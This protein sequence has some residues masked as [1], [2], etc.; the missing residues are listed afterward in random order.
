MK[1]V[2]L[3]KLGI[4]VQ[5]HSKMKLLG[6]FL[7]IAGFCHSQTPTLQQVT[8]AGNATT[9][10]IYVN[11]ILGVDANRSSII[12]GTGNS[13][14]SGGLNGQ[15]YIIG[16][17][18]TVYT[19]SFQAV[20][21]SANN[22]HGDANAVVGRHNTAGTISNSGL[23]L[24]YQNTMNS[25]KGMS[26]GVQNE[27]YAAKASAFGYI[28]K[29]YGYES[30]AL[31]I[32]NY[33]GS[34]GNRAVAFGVEN[35]SLGEK[36]AAFGIE[37]NASGKKSAAFGYKCTTSGLYSYAFGKENTVTSTRGVAIGCN[38]SVIADYAL[39]FGR[40]LENNV[41]SSVK[42]GVSNSA[43]LMI[44]NSGNVGIG[45]TDPK[46]KLHLI[47]S[48]GVTSASDNPFAGDLII[49]ANTGG[50]S[51][52]N[53]AMLEFNIPAATSGGNNWGQARIVTVAGNPYD[54]D[55]T[56][57]MILG[58]RRYNGHW[59]YGDDITIDGIGSVG[60]GTTN[61]NE[62]LHVNGNQFLNGY[63]SFPHSYG[64][65]NDGKIG[66]SQFAPGLDI[67][68]INNDNTFRKVQVWGQ[69]TQNQN[70]GTNTWV[71]ANYFNGNVGIG[72][73]SLTGTDY[74]LYV[75]TGI[76]TRKVKVDQVGWPDYV[77]RNEYKLL[78]LT[79][80]EKFILQNGHLPEVPSA[81][82][83]ER[84]GIN[85]GDN[86]ALLLKKVE[87]LTLYLIEFEKKLNSQN[88]T[89]QEQQQ[90]INKLKAKVKASDKNNNN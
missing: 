13:Y 54:N 6:I 72:T 69:I 77:F 60:I 61:P 3:F 82:E 10:D 25:D 44:L 7:T 59:V 14:L 9:N 76:R 73:T 65:A 41:A 55:A 36:S 39:A 12:I 74:K 88:V 19:S 87:E 11:R 51:T 63:L 4:C 30:S 66:N 64:D 2:S 45:T 1:P 90:E 68:G 26:V 22:V 85:L 79:D 86:Q 35:H 27:V 50:R 31:G 58:T 20:L 70:D 34:S 75:E 38:N 16:Y 83:V 81:E 78:S 21:G 5:K 24:G 33:T 47:G 80:L 15:S 52:T 43:Y 62:K 28:N 46:A 67:V 40:D 48:G 84:N 37:N 23:L 89:I 53:G 57:K 71:G 18:N 56:G 29:A 49:Q 8:T 32:A 17:Y 42:M